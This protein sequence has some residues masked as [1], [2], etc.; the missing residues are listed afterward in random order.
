MDMNVV[1]QLVGSLG[2]PIVFC[3][4]LFKDMKEQRIAFAD[5]LDALQKEHAE[6]SK[7]F[8][9]ALQENSVALQKL[10]TFLE[11]S[12]NESRNENP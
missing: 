10:T 5:S 12:L 9:T 2:F 3:F 7:G 11:V 8:Q 4:M 1:I 6:E